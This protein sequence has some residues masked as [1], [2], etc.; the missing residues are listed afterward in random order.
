MQKNLVPDIKNLW[1]RN[2]YI[3][4]KKDNFQKF[5]KYN[6]VFKETVLL[7]YKIAEDAVIYECK[8]FYADVI[9]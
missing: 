9:L 4:I 2:S 7:M 1:E 5:Q 6:F 8:N 3:Q